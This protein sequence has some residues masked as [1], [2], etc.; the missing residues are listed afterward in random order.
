MR[1]GDEACPV[2]EQKMAG[3]LEDMNGLHP[4]IFMILR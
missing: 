3:V 1:T 4:M 2:P